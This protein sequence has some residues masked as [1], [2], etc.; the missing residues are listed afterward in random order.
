MIVLEIEPAKLIWDA[1]DAAAHLGKHPEVT[2]EQVKA[3]FEFDTALAVIDGRQSE[4][5]YQVMG[6]VGDRLHLIVVSPRDGSW[7]LISARK[8]N[9]KEITRYVEHAEKMARG[10]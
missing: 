8:A 10:G 1:N 4:L 5:R 9:K 7:R 3:E 6:F 2:F